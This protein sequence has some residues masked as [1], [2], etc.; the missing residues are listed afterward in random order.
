MKGDDQQVVTL[1]DVKPCGL[2]VPDGFSTAD[3]E[4][5]VAAYKAMEAPCAAQTRQ[6]RLLHGQEDN[7]RGKDTRRVQ[8]SSRT[9]KGFRNA[10]RRGAFAGDGQSHVQS[11][12]ETRHAHANA[13][14]HHTGT[15]QGV[16]HTPREHAARPPVSK[17]DIWPGLATNTPRRLFEPRRSSSSSSSSSGIS[18]VSRS[19]L[20]GKRIELTESTGRLVM[21]QRDTQSSSV[22]QRRVQQV[23]REKDG[24]AAVRRGA[25]YAQH[26][27]QIPKTSDDVV[28]T[29]NLDEITY[30]DPLGAG[31]GYADWTHR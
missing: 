30:V 20:R 2:S 24:K 26:L 3:L 11:L 16:T 8:V 1:A 29:A 19:M 25:T 31:Q 7:L 21:P 13:A 28:V 22:G 27:A 4:R 9:S 12:S 6:T 10:P 23:Q 15:L 5:N 17:H 18:S 14:S